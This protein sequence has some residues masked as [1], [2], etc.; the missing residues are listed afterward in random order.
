MQVDPTSDFN[1]EIFSEMKGG[2][3]FNMKKYIVQEGSL[4][5]GLHPWQRLILHLISNH[6]WGVFFSYIFLS[7]RKYFYCLDIFGYTCSM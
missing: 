1:C 7:L 2:G 5:L 3:E 4:A 6:L